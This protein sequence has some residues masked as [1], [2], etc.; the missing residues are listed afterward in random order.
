ME[1][2]NQEDT[3][4]A[5]PLQP[6]RKVRKQG[7]LRQL[8]REHHTMSGRTQQLAYEQCTC[9]FSVGIW[10]THCMAI[11]GGSARSLQRN[12]FRKNATIF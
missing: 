11:K 4:L 7:E 3:T 6:Y 8:R 9:V 1:A 5:R 10:P 12:S 2:D